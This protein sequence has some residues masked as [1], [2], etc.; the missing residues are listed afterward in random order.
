MGYGIGATGGT[1]MDVLGHIPIKEVGAIGVSE[2]IPGHGRLIGMLHTIVT[3]ILD[4]VLKIPIKGH[5]DH[6]AISVRIGLFKTVELLH[7]LK[8][9]SL[10]V[11]AHLIDGAVAKPRIFALGIART[12]VPRV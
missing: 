4:G 8:I 9:H 12:H 2:T 5:E 1:G 10:V 6:Q 11:E 3:N 7:R